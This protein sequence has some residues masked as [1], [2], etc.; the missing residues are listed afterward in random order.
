MDTDTIE[1]W[2]L[3]PLITVD[4]LAAYLGLPKQTI[5]DW[6]VERKGP[7]EPTASAS[8]CGSPSAT[9]AP[10]SRRSAEGGRALMPRP[11]TPIGTY[12]NVWVRKLGPD[13]F[14]ASTRY[15]DWD[16]AVRPVSARGRSRTAAERTLKAKL[17]ERALTQPAYTA[18]TPDSTFLELV[19]YWLEDLDLEGH[20]A[21][22]TRGTYERH[23]P[24]SS[25]LLSST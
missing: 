22:S 20:L 18:I 8:T 2:G 4:E 3:E 17:A 1:S 14:E 15:R 23:M 16:G 25:S 11:R 10:G 21:P 7:E 9:C 6:R 24:T 13:R 5:Y 19:E 12:G